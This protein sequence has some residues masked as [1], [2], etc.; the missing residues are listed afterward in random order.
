MNDVTQTEF[1]TMQPTHLTHCNQLLCSEKYIL[2]QSAQAVISLVQEHILKKSNYIFKTYSL[3]KAIFYKLAL[4]SRY[5][6][7]TSKTRLYLAC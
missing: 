5:F 3:I 6:Y 2:D 4:P 1:D 7:N